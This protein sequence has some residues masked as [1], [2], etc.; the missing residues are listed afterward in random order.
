M[1][2]EGA[3]ASVKTKGS[4]NTT[5]ARG[6][7]IGAVAG[8]ALAVSLFAA[9]GAQAENCVLA[10]SGGVTNLA[11]LGSSP[12]SVSSMI[13][14]TIATA[15]TAFLLQSTAFIGSPANP[16]PDQQGGGIW[17]RGVS[18]QVDVKSSTNAAVSET[19][20]AGA[21]G[22]VACSQRV[23]ESFGGVQLGSDIAKLNINGWNFHVGT[24]AGVLE[25]SGTLVGGA[26]E[27][28]DP[29][30]PG[31]P[32]VGGG[33]FTGSTE[34]PFFGG[35]AAATYGGF[36][37][38]GL[39]RSEYYQTS[40][41]SPGTNLFGQII[42]AHSISF[43]SSVAYQWQVPNSNWFIEP[44]AGIIISRTKVDPLNFVGAGSPPGPGIPFGDKVNDTLQLND[45][46]SD[47]GRVGLRA[48]TT[49]DADQVIWQ[50]FAAVSVWH[51][52]GPSLTATSTTCPGCVSFFPGGGGAAV[53]TTITG[54]SST[55]TF[56]TYGQYSIGVSAALAGTGWVG[57]ARVDYRDGPDLE[58]LSGTGGIRYQFAPE[59]TAKGVMAVKAPVY[60]APVAQA[61]SWTGF[62]VGGF[63]G[64]ILGS[65]DWNFVGGGV[66][67]HI[68]GYDWGGN[69]GYD[70]QTGRWVLGVEGDLEKTSTNGGTACAPLAVNPATSVKSSP[71]FQMTCNA[72][73]NWLATAT[74]RV[75]YTWNRALVY[76]KGGGAWTDER[77]SATCN[78]LTG[79]FSCTNPAGTPSTGFT[80]STGRGGWVIGYGAEFALT[81]DWSARAETNYISFGE[82][83]VAASDGSALNVGMHLWETTIGLNYRFNAGSVVASY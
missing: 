81:P 54:T 1:V 6:C 82:S 3:G 52:F 12:A 55:S 46:D 66:S 30:N 74:A 53:P 48:G 24:T 58:G 11:A 17:V 22:V 4:A 79:A 45:I 67:P 31:G 8:V 75:G 51:E 27:F 15:N 35:Y 63:G 28:T 36:S 13:G 57:F 71:M 77:F 10:A 29:A 2:I 44:S 19:L 83:T 65:A 50:P 18:G 78:D 7:S 9:S 60:K 64:A 25:A 33:P 21:S 14:T 70:Y 26:F 32:A 62:H 43:S 68:A 20:P 34:I 49:I 38:D 72:Q 37:V 39:L 76:V 16:A 69:L 5:H 23:D 47:I 59:A 41:T 40:L 56:G 61:V 80:A 73:A 42:D